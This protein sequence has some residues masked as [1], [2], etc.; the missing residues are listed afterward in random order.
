MLGE[1][2]CRSYCTTIGSH[3]WFYRFSISS[4]EASE[5][6]DAANGDDDDADE[7]A[8]SSNDEEMTTSQ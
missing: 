8:S 3:R 2:S 6:E 4:P 5:D 1:H 7:D